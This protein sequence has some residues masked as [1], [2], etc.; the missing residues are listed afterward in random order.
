VQRPA[1]AIA[2]QH[3]LARIEPVLDRD[4]L[5]GARHDHGRERN[6]AVCHLREAIRPGVAER[7][8]DRLDGAARCVLIERQLATQKRFGLSR[9]STRL[10]SVTVGSLPPLP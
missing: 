7:A 5:D 1:A 9:P 6:D 4:L 2:E 3:E 8:P 10:A